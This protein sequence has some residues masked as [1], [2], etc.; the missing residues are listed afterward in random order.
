[1]V[2]ALDLTRH[3]VNTTADT[4]FGLFPRT[5]YKNASEHNPP[6]DEMTRFNFSVFLDFF[7][8][9]KQNNL[10]ISVLSTL[11]NK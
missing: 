2:F 6:V 5:V 7:S 11:Y 10:Q 9:H 4:I 1:M 3:Q 8:L